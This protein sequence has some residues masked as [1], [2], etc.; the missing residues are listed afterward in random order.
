MKDAAG[1]RGSTIA[2]HPHQQPLKP[3]R[4]SQEWYR[5]VRLITVALTLKPLAEVLVNKVISTRLDGF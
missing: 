1:S 5:H 2:H 3:I 4:R